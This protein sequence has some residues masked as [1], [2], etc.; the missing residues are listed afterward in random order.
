MA[1]AEVGDAIDTL[2]LV[3]TQQGVDFLDNLLGGR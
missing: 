2:D 1:V 3:V